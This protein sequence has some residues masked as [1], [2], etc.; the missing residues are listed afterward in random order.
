MVTVAR[1]LNTR[2]KTPQRQSLLTPAACAVCLL[3]LDSASRLPAQEALRLSVAGQDLAE[4]RKRQLDEGHFNMKWGDLSMRLSGRMSAEAT[5]NVKTVAQGAK[6]DLILRPQAD[7]FSVWRVSEKNSLTF[8]LGLGYSKYLRTTAYDSV[9]V[10]PDSD[11]SFDI[12]AGDFL[13]NLHDRF[14]YSQDVTYDPAVSGVGSLGRFE[15]TLGVKVTWDL[16][17]VVLSAGYDHRLY[18]S[19]EQQFKQL[20]HDGELFTASAGFRVRP[21]V[22]T[23]LEVGG[24]LIDYRQ[25]VLQ[26]NSH[27]AFGPFVSSELSEYTTVRLSGGY[28]LYSLDTYGRTNL[29]SSVDALYLDLSL[30]QRVNRQLSHS[31]AVTRTVQSGISSELIDIWHVADTMYWNLFLKTGLSTSLSFEHGNISKTSGETF[32]RYGFGFSLSRSFSSHLTGSM[33]YQFYL[34]DSD[35]S[36]FGYQQNRL[37]LDVVYTF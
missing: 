31:L 23:G 17:D 10:S 2:P 29:S 12:Y 21:N 25:A 11:L 7:L 18:L 9:F 16:N 19:T 22:T 6:S 30:R 34:K 32:D 3:L 36:N 33:S 26:D 35:T 28:V 15:N 14:D 13:I 4:A 20:S 8:G 37:V 1:L 24:G 5:D 27:I